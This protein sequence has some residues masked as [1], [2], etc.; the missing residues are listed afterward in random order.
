VRS[1]QKGVGKTLA[2]KQSRTV[3]QRAENFIA[4]VRVA[5]AAGSSPASRLAAPLGWGGAACCRR[6]GAGAD[7]HAALS[8]LSDACLHMVGCVCLTH[9]QC[10]RRATVGRSHPACVMQMGL[11]D[12]TV[13]MATQEDD[14]RKPNTG[15][16]RF[17]VDELNAGAAPGTLLNTCWPQPGRRA[18]RRLPGT[19]RRRAC[20][21][22][23]AA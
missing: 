7:L 3:R 9:P 14:Y 15:M 8:H 4:G 20:V 16:W 13:L 22:A 23:C 11:A 6:Q 18:S 12:V 21:L 1:N 17:F 10:A 5:L 19:P 2:G